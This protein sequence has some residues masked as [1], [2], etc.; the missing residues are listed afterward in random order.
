[1]KNKNRKKTVLCLMLI[2][3]QGRE[4]SF[5]SIVYHLYLS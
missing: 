1:M 3:A 5:V 4:P 2:T